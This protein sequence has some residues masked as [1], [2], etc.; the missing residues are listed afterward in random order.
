MYEQ[1]DVWKHTG[2]GEACRYRCFRVLQSN[3]YCVQ[4]RDFVRL[5]LNSK[6]LAELDLQLY[7][8]FLEQ[9][10]D[11]RSG[12]FASLEGAIAA[13]DRDFDE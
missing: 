8:L 10:P 11:E 13:H 7:E 6:R 4:S 5:P 9:P 12:T 1:I 2:P 3:T